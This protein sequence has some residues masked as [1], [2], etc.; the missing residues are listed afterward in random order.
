VFDLADYS[1]QLFGVVVVVLGA[2]VASVRV[3]ALPELEPHAWP[4]PKSRA[5]ELSEGLGLELFDDSGAESTCPAAPSFFDRRT[6]L[7]SGLRAPSEGIGEWLLCP[8]VEVAQ[9]GNAR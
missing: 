4:V 5:H 1:R 2:L 8:A 7:S 9:N 3:V 6:Q